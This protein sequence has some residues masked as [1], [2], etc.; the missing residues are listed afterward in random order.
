MSIHYLI[1][2]QVAS[3]MHFFLIFCLFKGGFSNL[4]WDDQT[5]IKNKIS[6]GGDSNSGSKSKKS[7]GKAEPLEEF[8]VEYAKSSRSSCKG[9]GDK[10]EKVHTVQILYFV[11]NHRT[12]M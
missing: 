8:A 6:G 1:P 3:V 10:I 12:W 9:C 2:C 7:G 5:A 11:I 4:R